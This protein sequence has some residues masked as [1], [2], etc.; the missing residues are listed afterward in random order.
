MNL[1][2]GKTAALI[3][4]AAILIS[5]L[6]LS[7]YAKDF[8]ECYHCNKTGQFHCRNCDNKGE[9]VC[10]GCGGK[11]KFECPGE[12]GKGKCEGGFY[13]CPSC[14][15]DGLSR[16]IPADGDAGPCGQ[17]GGSG[18]IECW[19]CHGAGILICD[20]CSGDGKNECTNV[21]CQRAREID[22]KC[23]YCKGTGYL[24]DG[25]DFPQE[26]NDGV[27]N[28]PEKGD[29]IITD[30]NSWTGYYY[31]TNET[32]EDRQQQ[33]GGEN[34]DESERKD[35][36][37]GRDYVWFI[38]VG[39]GVWDLEGQ[40]IYVTYRGD[41]VTGVID[42]K[43]NDG[44]AVNGI[45]DRNTH[46]YLVADDFK[47]ELLAL[48]GDHEYS[49]AS[50]DPKSPRVPFNATLS[51]E[52]IE[53]SAPKDNP[54]QDDHG[55][56]GGQ[57]VSRTVD[58]G[59]G[60]WNVGGDTVTAWINGEQISG[61]VRIEETEAIKLQGLKSDK[62]SV[63]LRADDGFY[64]TLIPSG[65]GEVSIGRFEEDAVLAEAVLRLVIEERKNEDH[66]DE[67]N[68]PGAPGD[69]RTHG[70]DIISG[71]GDQ[72]V[73]VEARV[74]IMTEEERNRYT[75]MPDD[76]L[77]NLSEMIRNALKRIRIGITDGESDGYFE[78]LAKTYG[79]DDVKD[80]RILPVSTDE[81]IDI[82]FPVKVT[83]KLQAGEL[84]GGKDIYVYRQTRD[85]KTELLGKAEYCTYEDGSIEQF[86]FFTTGFS[87][88]FTAAKELYP[89]VTDTQTDLT[90]RTRQSGEEDDKTPGDE[91]PFSAAVIVVIAV[92]AAAAVAAVVIIIV[93]KKKS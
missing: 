86:S 11:G 22:W 13:V 4:I 53:G 33:S 34:D 83:V 62:M 67:T 2:S 16:P 78:K 27:H 76:E 54:G 84:D 23:P 41:P 58:F 37:T 68:D 57:D 82:G 81:Y 80:G 92:C 69:D 40:H 48:N 59:G 10:D 42:V 91:K 72:P 88:F 49:V 18:K 15:G 64:V 1:R 36:A 89:N 12:E 9:T 75:G 29:H 61:T 66:H 71:D 14:N 43:Y 45:T 51:I 47:T 19:H 44:F 8:E 65:D 26:W 85:G 87:S 21:D 77:N 70:F 52:Y 39:S 3:L 60:S 25:P 20:R 79:F 93:K 32:D 31:G 74:E 56:P 90:D 24:G 30:H 50:R 38:D 73:S 5:L 17:C 46:V 28:V 35:P 6:P 7:S 63:Y 55:D